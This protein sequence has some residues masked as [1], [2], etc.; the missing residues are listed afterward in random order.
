MDE[1]KYYSV[2]YVANVFR[3]HEQTIRRWIRYK[4]IPAV[5]IGNKYRISGDTIN[6][7]KNGYYVL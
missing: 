6:K 2:N 4:K 3:I 1:E 7:I 5:K